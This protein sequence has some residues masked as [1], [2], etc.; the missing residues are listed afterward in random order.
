MKGRGGLFIEK[1]R[2]QLPD[3]AAD[4]RQPYVRW[5][6]HIGPKG[7]S[8]VQVL[9][10]GYTKSS[11]RLVIPRTSGVLFV[12]RTSGGLPSYVR[13]TDISVRQLDLAYVHSLW[14]SVKLLF[15][16]DSNVIRLKLRVLGFRLSG[17]TKGS[18]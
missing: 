5:S 18:G 4:V 3:R 1:I 8:Y 9:P 15:L 2:Y 17:F 13:T 7:V 11:V 10:K 12:E 6:V 14:V 16:E